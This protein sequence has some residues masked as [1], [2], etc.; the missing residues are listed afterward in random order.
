MSELE[1]VAALC[2]RLGASPAQAN[3]MAAQL[4]KR[5][6]Q[7]AAERGTSREAELRRL[8]ELVAKGHAGEVPADFVP[9]PPKP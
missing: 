8:L 5:T 1:Q 2:V 6:D 3:V 9:P 4:L 7:L